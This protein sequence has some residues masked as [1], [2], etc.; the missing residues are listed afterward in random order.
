MPRGGKREGAGRKTA[1]ESGCSFAETTV[2]RVPRYLKAQVLEL[3]HR[4]DAGETVDLV[5]QSILEENKSLKNQIENLQTQQVQIQQPLFTSSSFADSEQLQQRAKKILH[6][7]EVVRSR[8]RGAVRK[9]LSEL[10][11]VDKSYFTIPKSRSK[12]KKN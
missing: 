6:Q 5:P 8:D 2:V 9:F 11:S 4:L 3:A 12:Q 7:D 10:F 1:W